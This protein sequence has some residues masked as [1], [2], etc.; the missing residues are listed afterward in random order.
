[1]TTTGSAPTAN[2]GPTDTGTQRFAQ[3]FGALVDSVERAIHGKRDVISAALT[4]LLAEGHLLLEDVPGVGKTSLAK[5]LARSMQLGFARIQFTPDLLPSDVVGSTV[6]HA[7]SGEVQFHPGPVFTNVLLG[8]ELNRAS[9]KTQSA[10]LEAMEE[11]QVTADGVTRPLPEPFMVVATQNP[12]EHHGT[13]PL[14]ESQLDRFLMR[15]SVGY[16]GDD[17]EVSL[18]TEPDHAHALDRVAPVTD[19][20]TVSAMA[21]AAEGVHVADP[22][23]RYVVDLANTTRRDPDVLLG[24]SPR[25]GLGWL[26]AARVRAA[27]SGRDFVTPD[28]VKL[29]A[30][31]V[32]AHRLALS[33]RAASRSVDTAGYVSDLLTRVAVP[34]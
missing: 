15:L 12:V 25:A 3:L 4:C 14:P 33:G 16:P 18:L 31:P 13:F 19:P 29:L 9:P 23:A 2:P 28:D 17:H 27:A 1:M 30:E 22:V 11:S 7:G 26:R 24:V 21:R 34:T 5:A 20:S 6:W 8:D 32:L 10:L